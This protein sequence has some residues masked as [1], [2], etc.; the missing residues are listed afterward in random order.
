MNNFYSIFL[1]IICCLIITSCKD[2]ENESKSYNIVGKRFVSYHPAYN[3]PLDK[4]DLREMIVFMDDGK[5]SYNEVSKGQ[6]TGWYLPKGTY[7]YKSG[8]IDFQD[9]N[10]SSW[11]IDNHGFRTFVGVQKK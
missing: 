8:H 3:D 6:Y 5:F 2:D 4:H 1:S 9:N 11:E 7:T 10:I